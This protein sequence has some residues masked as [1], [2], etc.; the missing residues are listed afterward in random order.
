MEASA[1]AWASSAPS[2]SSPSRTARPS[3]TSSRARWRG[4]AR[5]GARVRFVLVRDER[6][7]ARGARGRAPGARGRG[8]VGA[9]AEQ[10]A[11]GRRR[12]AAAGGLRSG[13]GNGVVS[14][15]ASQTARTRAL[16][17]PSPFEFPLPTRPTCLCAL[18]PLLSNHLPPAAHDNNAFAATSSSTRTTS[19]STSPSCATRSRPRAGRCRCR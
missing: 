13:R 8:G 2:R 7:H 16:R 19:G 15:A 4:C 6:R 14:G 10:L 3:W 18:L 12:D 5:F 17:I 11:Q 9:D 1:P